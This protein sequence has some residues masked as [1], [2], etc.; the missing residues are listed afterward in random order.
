MN[1]SQVTKPFLLTH[2]RNV[3]DF[4]LLCTTHRA[5]VRE[6][7]LP[8]LVDFQKE[9]FKLFIFVFDFAQFRKSFP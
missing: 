6:R 4:F 1:S 8:S 3:D 7:N 2:T 9:R 5:R